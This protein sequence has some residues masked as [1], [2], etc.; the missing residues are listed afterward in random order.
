[1]EEIADRRQGGN[2][3]GSQNYRAQD[4]TALLDIVEEQLPFG[5][6][7]WARV[8]TDFNNWATANIRPNRKSSSLKSKFDRMASTKKPTGDPSCP[9]DVCRAKHVARD[10]LERYR[11]LILTVNQAQIQAT[12][13][14]YLLQEVLSLQ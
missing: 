10:M 5:A 11:R 2:R 6:N 13:A 1:M 7:M 14:L 4:V 3:S 8:R 12:K 9:S